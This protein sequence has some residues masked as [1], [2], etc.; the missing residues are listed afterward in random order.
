MTYRSV[1][2]KILKCLKMCFVLFLFFRKLSVFLLE[3][4]KEQVLRKGGV[5]RAWRDRRKESTIRIYCVRKNAFSRK[6]KHYIEE[7]TWVERSERI[8][9][10]I[11]FMN[12][13]R[14]TYELS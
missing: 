5:D 9:P 13:W 11:R 8:G 12:V 4:R 10:F 1:F 7:E 6:E 2:N 3:D 14:A